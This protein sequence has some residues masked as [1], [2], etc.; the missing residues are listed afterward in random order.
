ML[1]MEQRVR[2]VRQRAAIIMALAILA[3]G[4]W[5]GW[6]PLA[7]VVCILSCFA[8]AD[9]LMPKLARPEFLMFGAWVGSSIAIAVAVALSGRPGVSALS[10]MAIPVITLSTR[11]SMR[12]VVAGVFISIVAHVARRDPRRRRAG[13]SEP[14]AVD[15]PRRARTLRIRTHDAVDALG[16]PAP[17]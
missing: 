12:G 5:L 13:P 16:H 9:R 2:P 15:H 8:A 7:F 4:P 6:W 1:D 17:K 3:A 14:R 11:F 10:L